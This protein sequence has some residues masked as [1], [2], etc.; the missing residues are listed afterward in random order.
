MQYF[1]YVHP[2][3]LLIPTIIEWAWMYYSYTQL[4]L[5]DAKLWRHH[6]WLVVDNL[7]R[8][9]SWI[10]VRLRWHWLIHLSIF[11]S[12]VSRLIYHRSF[13]TCRPL[14][15]FCHRIWGGFGSIS[16]TISQSWHKDKINGSFTCVTPHSCGKCMKIVIVPN[17]VFSGNICSC[18]CVFLMAIHIM[19]TFTHLPV[20]SFSHTL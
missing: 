4:C 13:I 9:W 3:L 11:Q 16:Q 7:R 20:R 14:S 18:W 17:L 19:K 1:F 6:P 15:S 2:L 8:H 5:Y 10:R 12:V